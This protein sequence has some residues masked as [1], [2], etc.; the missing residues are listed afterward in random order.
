MRAV[1]ITSPGGPDV[2]E[3]TEVPAPGPGRGEVF[4][5]VL[6]AG[7]T[8][9]DLMQRQGFYPPPPGA[10]PYP[11]LECSGR[12]QA[13]G[14]PIT[15]GR[16]GDEVFALLS[17]AGYAELVAVPEGQLLP[18]PGTVDTTTAAAFPETA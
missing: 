18:I 6:T 13:V 2:L 17:G 14:D 15:S 4:I 1:V 10:P 5:D 12:V 9:A 8:P 11:G 7:V 3:F 16:P